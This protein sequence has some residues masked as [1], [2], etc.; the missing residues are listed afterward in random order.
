MFLIINLLQILFATRYKNRKNFII[1]SK[2]N[3]LKNTLLSALIFNKL[4]L[5]IKVD[6]K[7]FKS[8][9]FRYL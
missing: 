2:T 8:I 9:D 6:F 7:T 3:S 4:A 5:P 1:I